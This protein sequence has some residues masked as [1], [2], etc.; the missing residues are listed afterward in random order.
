MKTL[1]LTQGKVALVDDEDY[2]SLSRF[3]W[4]A[5]HGS[6]GVWYAVRSVNRSTVCMHAVIM[7]TPKGFHTDHLNG[8]GLDNQ[9]SNLKIKSARENI[10]NSYTHRSGRLV[11]CY[12][13]NISVFG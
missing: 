1:E 10:S 2:E 8:D 5:M 3:K 9:R 6:T 12:W 4:Y 7:K 13:N 11:G